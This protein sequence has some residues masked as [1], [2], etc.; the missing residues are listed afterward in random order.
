[1]ASCFHF[2][3]YI[4]CPKMA[5]WLVPNKRAKVTNASL[6]KPE[7]RTAITMKGEIQAV[8]S[9]WIEIACVKLTSSNSMAP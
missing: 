7:E 5:F 9:E 4:S 6:G 2:L 1:M 8:N 3:W